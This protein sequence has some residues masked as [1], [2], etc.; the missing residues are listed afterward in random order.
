MCAS[1]IIKIEFQLFS[2]HDISF[3][4]KFAEDFFIKF[5]EKME[6]KFLDKRNLE[7]LIGIIACY[8]RACKDLSKTMA[9]QMQCRN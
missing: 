8:V 9:K 5:S 3:R 7:A 4:K 6:H 1:Q 2:T